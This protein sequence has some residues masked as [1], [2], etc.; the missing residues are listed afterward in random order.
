MKNV[1]VE[2]NT[3]EVTRIAAKLDLNT[4]QIIRRIAFQIEGE[5]KQ[6]APYDTTAL[7]NSIYTRT[8][9]FDGYG[10]A[11]KAATS[12]NPEA[13]TEPHPEPKKNAAHVGPCVEYAEYVE[14]PG[15]VRKGGERPYLTPAAEHVAERYNNGKEWEDLIK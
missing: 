10:Q 15:A 3:E 9:E 5:A 11:S 7:R 6:N 1:K 14:Y 12:S 2:I 13:Q 4:E 8:S